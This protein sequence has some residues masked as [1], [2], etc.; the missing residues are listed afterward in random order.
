MFNN[1][2][3][4]SWN[5]HLHYFFP[6]YSCE[7]SICWH[8][9]N[10][11]MTNRQKFVQL[12]RKYSLSMAMERYMSI[13][14]HQ[15][16]ICQVFGH[17]M[18]G[19]MSLLVGYMGSDNLWSLE[20]AASFSSFFGHH[21]HV[22]GFLASRLTCQGPTIIISITNCYQVMLCVLHIRKSMT[23]IMSAHR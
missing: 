2:S 23:H 21:S 5:V 18:L 9:K 1:F 22:H 19:T 7:P 11:N 10:K 15:S 12:G 20:F 17:H 3:K 6:N 14:G 13:E 4:Y 16:A 8:P